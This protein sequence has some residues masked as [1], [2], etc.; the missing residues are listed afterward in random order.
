MLRDNQVIHDVVQII[1]KGN[2]YFDA[3][4]KIFQAMVDLYDSNQPVDLV[5]L[6]IGR[7][8]V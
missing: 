5:I 1:S 4:Q 8:H 6:E 3:H 2:F 7:A